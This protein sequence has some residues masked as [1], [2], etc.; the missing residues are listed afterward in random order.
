MRE[1][2]LKLIEVKEEAGA[3]LATFELGDEEFAGLIVYYADGE[4]AFQ[5]INREGLRSLPT[6]VRKYY[7][8]LEGKKFAEL[9][10][11][12]HAIGINAAKE[13]IKRAVSWTLLRIENDKELKALLLREVE[14]PQT[15]IEGK[16]EIHLT[17][18]EIREAEEL[19]KSPKL[20]NEVMRLIRKK[21]VREEKNALLVFFTMLS[22]KLKEP[23]NLRFSG[24]TSTGKSSL[25]RAVARLFP[26]EMLIIRTALTRKALYYSGLGKKLEDGS[27]VI[28][29]TGKVLVLL[30]EGNCKDFLDE[31]KPVL[32]HDL[33][34]LESEFTDTSGKTPIARRIVIRGFPAYIGL[35]AARKT[36]DEDDSRT[37]L[38]TPEKSGEK[39]RDVQL[40][41]SSEMAF[42][43]RFNGVEEDEK[44]VWNAIRVLESYDGVIIPFAPIIAENFP[45]DKP[46]TMRDFKKLLEMIQAVALLFQKKR[47]VIEK[48]GHRYLVAHPIDFL[49]AVKVLEDA[50]AD[51]LTNLEAD[52]REFAEWLARQDPPDDGERIG[53]TEKELRKLLAKYS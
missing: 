48:Y 3:I 11:Q 14:E 7:K 53:W 23:L 22:A 32:S 49:I 42:P 41:H 17:E 18:G 28:D 12:A 37:L 30:E 35:V 52:V 27:K 4:F 25:V 16:P 6:T 51:T 47:N 31:F 21:L 19:L 38:A 45:H 46:R 2:K 43:W 26:P 13:E 20:L 15:P 36:I 40:F 44:K 24:E 1:K 10:R 8:I 29:F 5:W 50:L 33:Y 9:A 34:Q 39:F